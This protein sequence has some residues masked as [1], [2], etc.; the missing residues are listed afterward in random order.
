MATS[1]LILNLPRNMATSVAVLNF[2]NMANNAIVLN[3]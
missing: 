2:Y 1:A 3:F